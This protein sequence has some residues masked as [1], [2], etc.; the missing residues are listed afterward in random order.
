MK[1]S[2]TKFA[3]GVVCLCSFL[4]ANENISKSLSTTSLSVSNHRYQVSK[5]ALMSLQNKAIVNVG[6]TLNI[7]TSMFNKKRKFS[8]YLKLSRNSKFGF[9][10][11]F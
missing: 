6:N 10:Y 11:K 9:K 2:L 4:T 7:D 3:V 8:L 5:D 1:G